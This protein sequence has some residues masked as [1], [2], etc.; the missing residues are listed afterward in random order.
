MEGTKIRAKVKYLETNE[1]PTRHFLREKRLASNKF[2]TQL[3]KSDGAVVDTNE[4]TWEEYTLFYEAIDSSFESYFL[5][6]CPL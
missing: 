5:R 4:G 3:I 6:K 2:I 1:K